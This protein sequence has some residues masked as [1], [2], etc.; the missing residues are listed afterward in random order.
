MKMRGPIAWRLALA[1]LAVGRP[2]AASGAVRS[3]TIEGTV[4]V[5]EL[6]ASLAKKDSQYLK[7]RG[8]IGRLQAEGRTFGAQLQA[9]SAALAKKGSEFLAERAKVWDLK[10]QLAAEKKKELA[11]EALVQRTRMAL[12]GGQ[13]STPGQA[14]A[15][16][17]TPPHRPHRA[18]AERRLLRAAAAHRAARAPEA[19]A[20]KKQAPKKPVAEKVTEP[21]QIIS[22]EDV[23]D[24]AKGSSDRD[25]DAMDAQVKAEDD[26]MSNLDMDMANQDVEDGVDGVLGGQGVG[27]PSA[28]EADDIKKPVDGLSDNPAA[29][30]VQ[31]QAAPVAPGSGITAMDR[32]VLAAEVPAL[33]ADADA[34]V[35]PAADV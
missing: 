14:N 25:L 20:S 27:A 7:E 26:K 34:D 15:G 17:T 19:K 6:R 8:D 4:V 28:Q 3:S 31:R 22:S 29:A 10:R 5:E 1:V 30:P 35:G 23:E 32:S 24:V 9:T 16:H 2:M 33:S 13:A 11:L 12:D 18:E 21:L